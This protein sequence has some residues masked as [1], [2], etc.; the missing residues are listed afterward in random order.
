MVRFED[1][2]QQ[3]LMPG[4]SGLDGHGGLGR[5]SRSTF[6]LLPDELGLDGR[7]HLVHGAREKIQSTLNPKSS[8]PV[9]WSFPGS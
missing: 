8:L 5:I 2:S 7:F 6:R 4:G 9:P 1:A 3:C